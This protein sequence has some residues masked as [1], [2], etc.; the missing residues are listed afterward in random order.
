MEKSEFDAMVNRAKE[1][2]MKMAQ[3]SKFQNESIPVVNEMRFKDS[4]DPIT[5]EQFLAQNPKTGFLKIQAFTAN[6]AIPL[7]DVAVI[8]SKKFG[9]ETKIFYEVKTDQ[10]GIADGIILPAPDKDLSEQPSDI[11]PFAVY[12]VYATHPKYEQ[13]SDLQTQIFDGVKSIQPFN[14][15]PIVT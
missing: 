5:Y 10:N 15:V 9:D 8:I 12:D 14:M 4:M 13:Q 2:M 11:T 1:R 3:Q 7:S 6:Q